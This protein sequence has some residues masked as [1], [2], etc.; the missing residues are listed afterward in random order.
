VATSDDLAQ[1][2]QVLRQEI[3]ALGDYSVPIPA[4]VSVQAR[5]PGH[6][7]IRLRAYQR[8][9]GLSEAAALIALLSV[10]LREA[11]V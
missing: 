2:L 5:L 3:A 4:G 1:E 10:G 7:A 9:H 6:L 8:R 11:E